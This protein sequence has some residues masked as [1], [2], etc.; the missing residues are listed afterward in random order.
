MNPIHH[1]VVPLPEDVA[2][3]AVAATTAPKHGIFADRFVG[4]GLVP[5]RSALGQHDDLDRCLGLA[6]ASQQIEYQTSH[7]G[8]LSSPEVTR[9]M[10]RWLAR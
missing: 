8:L 10:R 4:D 2:C 5:L 9:H 3:Y 7:M 6:E 1:E